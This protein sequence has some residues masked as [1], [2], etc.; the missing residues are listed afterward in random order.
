MILFDII[1]NSNQTN[2]VWISPAIDYN[3]FSEVKHTDVAD[4]TPSYIII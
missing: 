4:I 2:L 3:W 1:D